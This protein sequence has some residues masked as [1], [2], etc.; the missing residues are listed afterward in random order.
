MIVDPLGRVQS[1]GE[2]FAITNI[3]APL[4]VSPRIPLYRKIAAYPI[5]IVFLAFVLSVISILG[6]KRRKEP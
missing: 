1:K 5:A 2:M 4:Y 3:T 6:K